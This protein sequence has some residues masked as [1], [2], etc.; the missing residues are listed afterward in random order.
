M[1]EIK[2]KRLPYKSG[3]QVRQEVVLFNKTTINIKEK[4][5]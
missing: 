2:K 4:F 3:Y 5:N 1:K